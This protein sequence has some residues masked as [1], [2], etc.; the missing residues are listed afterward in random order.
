MIIND[1]E[2]LESLSFLIT[3]VGPS[4]FIFRT[5]PKGF[6]IYLILGLVIN[7]CDENDNGQYTITIDNS[8]SSTA[9][10]IVEPI[11]EKVR[12]P[13][14]KLESEQVIKAGFRKLLPNKLN[15]D[16]DNDF[17]LECEVNDAKQITDWY[18]DDDLIEP[19]TP[20]FE[21]IN[22]GPVRKLKGLFV[23]YSQ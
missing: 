12:S 4:C 11:E 19:N 14:P 6:R 1:K 22:D 3:N 21:T 15:V 10:V 2:F 16:E 7:D 17:I 18:L 20:R 23:V 8:K 9:E 5:V 13:S